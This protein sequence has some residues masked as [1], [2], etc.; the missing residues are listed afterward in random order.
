MF[1]YIQSE[2]H[3]W[4]VGH[5]DPTGEFQPES[6]WSSSQEAADRVHWLNGG[7]RESSEQLVY[8]A[9]QRGRLLPGVSVEAAQRLGVGEWTPT[10]KYEK[11]DLVTWK[12]QV[13][14]LLDV[15]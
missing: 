6:D 7:G 13:I 5:Y 11:F 8:I 12:G 14:E 4:T 3:V 9:G 1:V 15:R 2:A 10:V